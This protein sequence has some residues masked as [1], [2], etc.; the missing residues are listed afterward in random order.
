MK[1]E[2]IIAGT[3]RAKPDFSKLSLGMIIPLIPEPENKFDPAAIRCQTD[4]GMKLGYIR[5]TDTG[6]VRAL[7]LTSVKI[8]AITPE[9]KWN[10]IA[11]EGGE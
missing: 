11:I 5:K 2:N 4:D 1:Y 7:N 3:P 9:S 6:L 8:I 10:E